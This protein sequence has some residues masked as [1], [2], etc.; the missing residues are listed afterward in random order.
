MRA[1]I[2]V[3]TAL[4]IIIVAPVLVPAQTYGPVRAELEGDSAV[5]AATT[6]L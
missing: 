6:G 5:W 2:T 1:T 3:V 4:L